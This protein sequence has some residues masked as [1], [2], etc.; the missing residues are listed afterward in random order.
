MDEKNAKLT[1]QFNAYEGY[2]NT[3]SIEVLNSFNLQ[4]QLKDTVSAI[5]NKLIDLLSEMKRFKLVTKLV[6]EFT[7]IE[8]DDKTI[9]NRFCVNS[10]VKIVI[11]ES[12]TKAIL[13]SICSTIM[14]SIQ[15][16]LENV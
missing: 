8:N 12:D 10:K 5:K 11:N 9:Y 13:E 14:S 7:Y 15:I 4:L 1:K 3:Y 6:L 2:A 16:L